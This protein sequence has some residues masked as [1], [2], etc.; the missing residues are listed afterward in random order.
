VGKVTRGVYENLLR[1]HTGDSH[2]VPV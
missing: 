2:R 1:K